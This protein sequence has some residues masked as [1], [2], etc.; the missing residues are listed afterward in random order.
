MAWAGL[1]ALLGLLAAGGGL[2]AALAVCGGLL[3]AFGLPGTAAAMPELSAA[4]AA[5]WPSSLVGG[6]GVAEAALGAGAGVVLLPLLL[7][8]LLPSGL[9]GLDFGIGP[10]SGSALGDAVSGAAALGLGD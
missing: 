5:G 3:V 8:L 10:E 4:L 6:S 1:L 2:L 7:L 9:A